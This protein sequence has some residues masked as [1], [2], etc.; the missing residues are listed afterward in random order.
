MPQ[1]TFIDNVYDLLPLLSSDADLKADVRVLMHEHGYNMDHYLLI[2]GTADIDLHEMDVVAIRYEDHQF[3]QLQ[4]RGVTDFSGR[5]NEFVTTPISFDDLQ[6]AF[7]MYGRGDQFRAMKSALDARRPTEIAADWD[8]IA[9]ITEAVSAAAGRAVTDK[10]SA[11]LMR[12]A[13]ELRQL[14]A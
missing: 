6:K 13:R 7:D 12:M 4:V 3:V 5:T 14:A 10:G 1:S 11:T 2:D 9:E 8:L